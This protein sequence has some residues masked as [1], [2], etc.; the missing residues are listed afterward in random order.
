MR[1]L[2][3]IERASAFCIEHTLKCAKRTARDYGECVCISHKI[4][5]GFLLDDNLEFVT[6]K[7]GNTT[8]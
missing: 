8:E 6:D 1:A 4:K 7:N 3:N 2:S 5:D